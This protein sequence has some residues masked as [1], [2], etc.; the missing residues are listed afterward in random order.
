[1][2]NDPRIDGTEMDGE[3][4]I[5]WCLPYMT[6]TK[7]WNFLDPSSLLVRYLSTVYP[8]FLGSFDIPTLC[9]LPIMMPPQGTSSYIHRRGEE[10]GGGRESV[11]KFCSRRCNLDSFLLR[12]SVHRPSS[13]VHSISND[14]RSV[15]VR[16]A[17]RACG[18]LARFT[19]PTL[20]QKSVDVR[21]PEQGQA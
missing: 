7:S 16:H 9:G 12:P 19:R 6:S 10:R 4:I 15:R 8:Q 3:F 18:S 14:V 5:L 13:V 17:S 2:K 1:M 20:M 21:G 11:C